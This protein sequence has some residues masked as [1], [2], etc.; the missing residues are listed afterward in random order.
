MT[1]DSLPP[2]P[3]TPEQRARARR[4]FLELCD[5]PADQRPPRL[6]ALCAG[7]GALRARVEAMLREDPGEDDAFTPLV[8]PQHAADLAAAIT[9]APGAMI[10]PY[11]ILSVL[12][13]GGFGTVF[14]AEQTAPI[15]RKV[16]LKVIKLGMDTRQVVAR[17]EQERQAMALLDHP[18]IAK[19]FDAGAAA[20]GRPYFAM[21]VCSGEPITRF[22]DE[23]RLPIA[24]RLALVAQVCRAIHHAHQRGLIHRD[25]KPSNILVAQVDGAP[26]PKII[27]FGIAKAAAPELR[28]ATLS[29]Q[30]QLIGTPEYMSPEQAAGEADLDTRTDVYALGI[31]LFELLTGETPIPAGAL[32]GT[33]QAALRRVLSDAQSPAP[34]SRVRARSVQTAAVAA[35]RGTDAPRLHAALKRELDWVILKAID[36]DRQRR[37]GSA[38]E[39]A[40]DLERYLAGEAVSAA[41][42]STWYALRKAARRHRGVAAAAA[43][44]FVALCL[45]LAGTIWQASQARAEAAAARTAEA[46]QAALAKREAAARAEAERHQAAA[47]AAAKAEAARTRELAAVSDF[48]ADML[49]NLDPYT[50]GLGLSKDLRDRLAAALRGEPPDAAAASLDAFDRA[51]DRLNTSDVATAIIDRDLLQPSI[52]AVERRFAGNPAVAGALR[53]TIASAYDGLGFWTPALQQGRAALSALASVHPEDHPDVVRARLLVAHA[54]L[55]LAQADEAQCELEGLGPVLARTL[56]PEDPLRLAYGRM[57]ASVAFAARR[58]DEALRLYRDQ[59]DL[60]RRVHPPLSGAVLVAVADLSGALLVLKRAA[61]AEPLCREAFELALTLQGP[62]GT[63]TLNCGDRLAT[64]LIQLKRFEEAAALIAD[65]LPRRERLSGRSNQR[66]MDLLIHRA[67]AYFGLKRPDL[68]EA[69]LR[70][71]LD[72]CGDQPRFIRNRLIVLSRLGPILVRRGDFAQAEDLLLAAA[73]KAD[74]PGRRQAVSHLKRVYARWAAAD[75]AVD[76]DAK[77]RLAEVLLAGTPPVATLPDPEPREPEDPDEAQ[78]P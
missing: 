65:L 61:E 47:E 78:S 53:A 6:D 2:D 62:A 7:D 57:A 14:L 5:L 18:N 19:V 59:L 76:P 34:S 27:D 74:A 56:P 29:L 46:R 69:D 20:S 15:R 8:S 50:L 45:G 77:L 28:A 1:P 26:V 11:R 37:Y 25:L 63:R 39:L 58:D 52:A 23:S 72:L 55:S 42:P 48:Q 51:L 54:L 35:A 30:H 31:L 17:F 41:P 9:E 60:V 32:R 12:G 44:V 66:T 36:K 33:P 22:C 75:A 68:A 64:A 38:A 3:L 21:E 24:R 70:T 13:E 71:V 43:A 16:A 67:G 4:L 10:G 73:L 49:R 40:A